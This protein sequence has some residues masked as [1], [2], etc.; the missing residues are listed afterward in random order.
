MKANS[1]FTLECLYLCTH[2]TEVSGINTKET[3]CR[4]VK[5]NDNLE[6]DT[7]SEIIEMV[8]ILSIEN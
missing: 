3:K 4:S 1:L 7:S 6:K 5:F 8:S 2:T